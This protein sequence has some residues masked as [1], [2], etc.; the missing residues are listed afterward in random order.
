MA[1]VQSPDITDV[2]PGII[3][4]DGGTDILITG[5]FTPGQE[6]FGFIGF[7]G[8][9]RDAPIYSGNQGYGLALISSNGTTLQGIA[10]IMPVG[11]PVLTLK[12]G[13]QYHYHL[14]LDVIPR[15]WPNKQFT[16]R[17]KFQPIYG[18]GKRTIELEAKL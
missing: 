6:I 4:S 18:V 2:S 12:I 8:D 3:N 5:N 10:P 17:K 15:I 13:A 9:E 14:N 11:E 1:F 7:F 16:L